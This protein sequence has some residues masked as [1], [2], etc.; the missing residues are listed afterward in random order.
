[1]AYDYVLKNGR[2]VDPSSGTDT[3]PDIAISQEKIAS[4]G[5][6]DDL[7]AAAEVF[8]ASGLIVAPGLIDI[9]L[10]AYGTLGVL[11]PDTLG[12]LSGVTTMVDAGSCGAYN[13]PEMQVLL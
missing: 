8:D 5:K 4:I 13:Y 9:H 10:H 6:M 1:M 3:I 12:V 2:L 7:S 11:N